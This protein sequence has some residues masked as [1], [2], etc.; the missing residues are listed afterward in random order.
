MFDGGLRIEIHRLDGKARV[1]LFGDGR[2]FVFFHY[3]RR[4][5][6]F[7]CGNRPVAQL[8]QAAAGD[9]EDFV[10]VG[11]A[12]AQRLQ[13]ILQA[14]HGV[15]QGVELLPTRHAALADQFD[16]HVLAHAQQIVGRFRHV[17][18]AQR[19][20]HFGKQPGDFG[21]FAVVPVGLDE[22]DEAF[23]RAGEIVDGFLRQDFHGALRFGTGQFLAAATPFAQA[24]DLV[25]QRRVDVQ[26]CAGDIQQGAFVSGAAAL[27]HFIQRIALLQHHATGNAQA[28][29]AQG[30]GHVAQFADLALQ[31]SGFTAGAQVQVQCV[32]DAQQFFL[33]HAT[34]GVQQR[35]VAPAD[36][37]AGM[38]EFGLAG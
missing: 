13:V 21:Q 11:A 7:F 24:R 18:H 6:H 38:V 5:Q 27:H 35:A 9:V 14:G 15:G 3:Q 31:R 8:F 12:F 4:L 37:A 17:Q 23:A 32:L 10:A 29:H 20:C 2:H 16:R 28:H 36:A 33:D 34:H 19:A 25:V 26:Q 1:V 22:G 30:V